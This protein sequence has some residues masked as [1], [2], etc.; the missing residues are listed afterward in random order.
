MEQES[1]SSPAY[2]VWL[3]GPRGPWPQR[4]PELEFGLNDWL[5]SRVLTYIPL[6]PEESVLSL[7]ELASRYPPP[8]SPLTL[9][10]RK[11]MSRL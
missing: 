6:S 10:E 2:F 4:W 3:T 9:A 7:G 5:L 11:R 1:F 8:A